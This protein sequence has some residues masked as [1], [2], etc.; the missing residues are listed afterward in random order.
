[1][2][3][4]CENTRKG[5]CAVRNQNTNEGFNYSSGYGR[6]VNTCV[7]AGREQ[8]GLYAKRLAHKN[9]SVGR[10]K[11]D[12]VAVPDPY[13]GEFGLPIPK[14]RNEVRLQNRPN[15]PAGRAED[16]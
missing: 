14:K 16:A 4:G 2:S 6:R 3:C 10:V 15:D 13:R 1:M 11:Y 9:V 8:W 5:Q 12:S 7:A